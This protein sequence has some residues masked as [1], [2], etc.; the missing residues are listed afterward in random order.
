[1]R[2]YKKLIEKIIETE[3]EHYKQNK[4]GDKEAYRTESNERGRIQFNQTIA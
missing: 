2:I 3:L 1:M 4:G